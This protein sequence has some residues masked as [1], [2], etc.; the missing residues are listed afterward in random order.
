M[1]KDVKIITINHK[2]FQGTPESFEDIINK[3]K[4]HVYATA[5]A[6]IY[7]HADAEDIMQ[8]TFIEAYFKYGNLIEKSKISAWL[9]SIARN[10]AKT[11][12]SRKKRVYPDVNLISADMSDT[13]S[14]IVLKNECKDIIMQKIKTLSDVLRETVILF[15]FGEKSIKEISSILSVSIGT[16]KSRLYSA[17]KLLKTEL[18]EMM[19]N[20]IKQIKELDWMPKGKPKWHEGWVNGY[21]R[22]LELIFKYLSEDVDYNTIMGD[23]GQAFIIQGDIGGTNLIDGAPD[24]GWWPLEPLSV[25]RLDF[26]ERVVGRKIMDVKPI[27]DDI[28]DTPI[29]SFKKHFKPFVTS[30]LDKN[31]PCLIQ[32]S[33]TWYIVTGYDNKENKL[34]GMCLNEVEGKEKINLIEEIMPPYCGISVGNKINGI[35]RKQADIK[36]LLYAIALHNDHILGEST[37]HISNY[38]TRHKE[39]FNKHWRTGKETIA[40]WLLCLENNENPGK[41][42]WHNNVVGHIKR[43]R[44]TAV[45]YLTAMQKRHD[46]QFAGYL[47]EAI[48]CYNSV[49]EIM[50]SAYINANDFET[51]KGRNKLISKIKKMA[52]LESKAV[53]SM[54]KAAMSVQ[55]KKNI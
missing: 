27:W 11:L 22:G 39:A 49:V 10:K 24:L 46:T 4:M 55:H 31:I 30:A 15:Y 43:N 14:D 36:A 29:S 2:S 47:A 25:M 8:E 18:V 20:E 42:F 26:L 33:A 5:Y 44:I 9:C 21:V 3:N 16:V 35:D 13:P 23:L 17:R 38:S 54:L 51:I 6:Y 53:E 28:K 52:S 41:Y 34:V 12:Y 50:K 32:M 48:D 19:D 7:N 40:A 45:R 1:I 37:K